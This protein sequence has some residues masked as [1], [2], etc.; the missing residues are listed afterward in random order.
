M[1]KSFVVLLFL[2]L[3]SSAAFSQGDP[4]PRHGVHVAYLGETLTHP[5]LSIGYEKYLNE[6]SKFQV[7]IRA[8]IGF[9]H[10]YRNNNTYMFTLETGFRRNFSSGLFLEQSLGVGYFYRQIHGDGQ[11]TVNENGSIVEK[12]SL[13]NSFLPFVANVGL[14][15]HFQ[16][17]KAQISPFLRPNFYWKMP[18]NETSNMQMT[19]MAGILYSFK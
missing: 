15:Y 1:K 16:T 12:G 2:L 13:G 8:N 18:F 17:K 9:Y 4:G 11:F 5:G 3:G 10:H 6:D 14:G 19:V 7:F